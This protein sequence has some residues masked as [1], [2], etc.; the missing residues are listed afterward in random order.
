MLQHRGGQKG[1]VTALELQS[2]E[3]HALVEMH[4]TSE[5][6]VYRLCSPSICRGHLRF[7]WFLVYGR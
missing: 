6:L 2:T 5:L 7:L 4:L 3:V 1:R